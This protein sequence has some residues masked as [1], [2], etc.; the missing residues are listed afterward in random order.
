M[1]R[2]KKT[3][4]RDRHGG[5]GG[6]RGRSETSRGRSGET[7]HLGFT[8]DLEEGIRR[9]KRNYRRTFRNEDENRGLGGDELQI[10]ATETVEKAETKDE[11]GRETNRGRILGRIRGDARSFGW[12]D[13]TP[14]T[15][16]L[17]RN[18]CSW[19]NMSRCGNSAAAIVLPVMVV[20]ESFRHCAASQSI[21]SVVVCAC[22]DSSRIKVIAETYL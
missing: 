18:Q 16:V 19:V 15:G 7:G 1:E 11:R 22:R 2:K 20:L 6:G 4:R 12:S 8:E 13:I 10:G 3:L 21:R 17:E 14:R 5:G 9:K